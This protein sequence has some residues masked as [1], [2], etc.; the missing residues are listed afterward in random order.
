M[1]LSVKLFTWNVLSESFFTPADYPTYDPSFF[2]ADRKRKQVLD[3]VSKMITGGHLIVLYEVCDG[4]R[5]ELIQ[6]ALDLDY[7]LRDAYYGSEESGNMGIAVLWPREYKLLKYEQVVVGQKIREKSKPKSC[8]DRWWSSE[9]D[10]IELAKEERNVM[11]LVTLQKIDSYGR[12][13]PKFTL[14]GYQMP[15]FETL[16][17]RQLH[18]WTVHDICRKFCPEA[19]DL[20]L[21]VE[22]SNSKIQPL[23][24]CMDMM[25]IT[26]RDPL[27][28][29][30]PKCGLISAH[31]VEGREPDFTINTQSKFS[32]EVFK[33]TIDYVW[34]NLS[35]IEKVVSKMPT[36]F[37]RL[38][39][40][41]KFPSDHYWMQF[42]LT[43]K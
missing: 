10:P 7:V 18:L 25:N 33:E 22:E 37:T 13:G 2:D 21:G 35:V 23:M 40:N 9:K 28:K 31:V 16:K 3:K 14:A 39:P 41:D 4:L 26:P 19:F 32:G 38:L 29:Y 34:V 30:F 11:I 27:Y 12:S 24:L 6:L 1:N 5:S 36:K 17:C 15:A 20:R 43:F 42:E 8:W